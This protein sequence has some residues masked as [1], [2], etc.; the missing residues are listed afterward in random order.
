MIRTQIYLTSRQRHELAAIARAT[1]RRQSE[2]VR[3]A[4]D[5]YIEDNGLDRRRAVLQR[6]AGIWR[7]RVD[8]P[9]LPELRDTWHRE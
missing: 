8:L 3:E 9:G 7:D 4:L 5:R 1:D 6:A 2:I